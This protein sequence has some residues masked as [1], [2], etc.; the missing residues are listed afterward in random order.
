MRKITKYHKRIKFTYALSALCISFLLIFMF[1]SVGSFA[2]EANYYVVK[3]YGE[4]VGTSN[5]K[6][7]AEIALNQA[8]VRMSEEAD[9]IVYLDSAFTIE[10]LN[11]A[12]AKTDD[13]ETLTDAIYEELQYYVNENFI[14]AI[15]ISADDYSLTVDSIDTA[16]EVLRAI[17]KTGDPNGE[18]TVNLASEKINDFNKISYAVEDSEAISSQIEEKMA[19]EDVTRIAA[20]AALHT[21]NDIGF[22]DS[23]TIRNVY[24]DKS[25]VYYGEEA[26]EKALQDNGIGIKTVTTENY[27]EQFDGPIQYVEDES[28]YSGREV[29][30]Y[31]GVPGTRN[32]TARVSRVN[33]VEVGREILTQVVIVEPVSMIVHTGTLP[34]PTFVMPIDNAYFSS[35]FGYRW[36]TMH[37]GN[38][39]AGEYGAPIY[40][41]AAGTVELAEYSDNGYGIQVIIRHDDHTQ[42]RY[43]HMSELNCKVG[44]YV[45]QYQ[46]IGYEGST[47]DSTGPHVHFE[48]II[49]G[50]AVDPLIYLG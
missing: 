3:I 27:D 13:V 37:L 14:Q 31:E 2:S 4:V 8:R 12:F 33:G 19:K 1:N 44:D 23:M 18:Y 46:V 48:I 17:E 7:K 50:V 45:A 39:Y 30:A 5:S 26:V 41:S 15:M 16:Q 42:T 28:I 9:S 21:L 40:A 35:G 25:S 24:T 10:P 49:D 38:D 6:E 22:V 36:G 11:K 43:A 20:S 32:V 47:G 34:P 29:V